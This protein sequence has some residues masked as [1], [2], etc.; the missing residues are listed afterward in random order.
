MV[1]DWK[2]SRWLIKSRGGPANR[3]LSHPSRSHAARRFENQAPL[4]SKTR[5]WRLGAVTG[6]FA[7]PQDLMRPVT[8]PKSAAQSAKPRARKSGHC[9]TT[10]VVPTLARSRLAAAK[11]ELN[12]ARLM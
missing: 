8:V 12:G 2:D 6:R 10:A 5:V 3:G 9:R 11:L 7:G 4:N 1:F